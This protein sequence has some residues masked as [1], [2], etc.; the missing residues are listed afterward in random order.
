[1]LFHL[2]NQVKLLF[3]QNFLTKRGLFYYQVFFKGVD[4]VHLHGTDAV[5]VV[6]AGIDYSLY[7]L[8]GHGGNMTE[9]TKPIPIP[10]VSKKEEK[11][12]LQKGISSD[13]N[14]SL[15]QY[16]S[17]QKGKTDLPQQLASRN[18]RKGERTYLISQWFADKNI[19]DDFL[20]RTN[21][22]YVRLRGGFA[23]NF[24]GENEY[25]YS[26]TARLKIPRTRVK[27]MI[28]T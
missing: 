7:R 10:T 15:E 26:I 5:I 12:F 16:L 4:T 20:D 6:G 14:E 9:V 2:L 3:Y 1:M 11:N 21:R 25:I 19:N 22:S 17:S 18:I 23:Y 13:I 8:L 27:A 28:L 24:R